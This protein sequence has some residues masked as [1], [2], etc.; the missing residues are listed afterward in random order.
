MQGLRSMTTLMGGAYTATISQIVFT[1]IAQAPN[2]STAAFRE[3]PAFTSELVT[4]A[5]KETEEMALLLKRHVVASSTGA[6][7]FRV[8]A[9]CVR[10][11]LGHCFVLEGRGLALSSVLVRQFRPSIEQTLNA[12][13]KRIEQISAALASADEWS[14]LHAPPG[15]RPLRFSS[16]SYPSGAMGSQPRLSSSAHKFNS[17]IQEFIEDMGHLQCLQLDGPTMEGVLQVFNTYVGLLMAVEALFTK[18]ETW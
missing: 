15:G 3:E 5:I 9:E 8:A 10:I 11:C 2:D 13:L 6:G 14:L 12:N 1:S 18:D 7:G 17:M 4:W 16:T